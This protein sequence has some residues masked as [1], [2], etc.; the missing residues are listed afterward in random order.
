MTLS[1]TENTL[2]NTA[3]AMLLQ[4]VSMLARFVTQTVFVYT[5]GKQY[6]GVAGVFSDLLHMLSAMELG[7]GT[8]VLF[9]LYQPI[10][11]QN[12]EMICAYITLLKKVYRVVAVAIIVLGVVMLP[13][14]PYIVKDIPDIRENI[15]LIFLLFVL[16]TAFSYLFQYR[17]ILFEAYQQKRVLSLLSCIVTVTVTAVQVVGLVITR[18]YLL[19]LLL[20]IAGVILRNLL[21]MWAYRRRYPFLAN[22]SA[23]LSREEKSLVWKNVGSLSLYRVSTIA[24]VGTDSVIISSLLGTPMVG[25][26]SGYRMIVNY[27]SDF[28]GQFFHS[29]LPSVGNAVVAESAEHNYLIYRRLSFA[30]YTITSVTATCLFVL[31]TPFVFLWLGEEYCLSVPVVASLVLNYYTS[32][33]MIANTSF[34]NAYGLFSKRPEAPLV[35]TLLNIVFSIM[36]G[37]ICGVFGILLAT[38]VA[39]LMT[40]LWVDPMLIYRYAFHTQLKSYSKEFGIRFVMTFCSCMLA[41]AFTY[42]LP[43]RFGMLFVRLFVAIVTSSA[44]L[45]LRYRRTEEYAFVMNQ[46]SKWMRKIKQR[47]RK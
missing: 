31:L 28:A 40:L 47:V 24:L 39:R 21:V 38:S 44:L 6:T 32:M 11:Q 16:K 29:A 12:K 35:M 43:Y 2:R 7:I 45:W 34:R 36:L 9:S 27:V 5:L 42:R 10:R 46:I 23:D 13:F 30:L 3:A 18:Q 14:L 19:F 37:K 22:R 20:D 1:R 17:G 25:I 33:M 8:A 15:Y 4:F 41:Y 26:L